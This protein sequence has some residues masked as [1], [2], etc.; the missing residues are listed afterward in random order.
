MV[1]GF[2]GVVLRNYTDFAS[3][4]D[5]FHSSVC[6]AQMMVILNAFAPFQSKNYRRRLKQEVGRLQLFE[7]RQC[8]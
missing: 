1:W 2:E 6:T 8:K 4:W 3:T 7:D 5:V